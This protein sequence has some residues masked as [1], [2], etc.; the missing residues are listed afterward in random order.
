MYYFLSGTWAFVVSGIGTLVP[1]L[2][3]PGIF[4]CLSHIRRQDS[5][6]LSLT[7]GLTCFDVEYH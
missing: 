6:P 3:A 5:A 7:F 2:W 1:I 4:S